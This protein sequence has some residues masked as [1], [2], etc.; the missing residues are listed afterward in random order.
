[1][2][3]IGTVEIH[4]LKGFHINHVCATMYKLTLNMG[5]RLF[6]SHVSLVGGSHF[7]QGPMTDFCPN[8]PP[9]SPTETSENKLSLARTWSVNIIRCSQKIL[10]HLEMPKK[11][12]VV[13]ICNFDILAS[14]DKCQFIE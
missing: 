11:H 2:W 3:D 5:N 12:R 1:M 8:V 13:P 14:L 10:G 7:F 9:V 4:F 6:E